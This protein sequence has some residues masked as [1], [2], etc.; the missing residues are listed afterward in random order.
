MR[1]EHGGHWAE[2]SEEPFGW[3]PKGRIRDAG[4]TGF[5]AGFALALVMDRVTTWSRDD[6][7]KSASSWETVD[8]AFGDRIFV[9][10]FDVWKRYDKDPNSKGGRSKASPPASESETPA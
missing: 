1:V 6:D 9:A 10:A 4:Y 7:P 5:N 2:V 8:P 3:L